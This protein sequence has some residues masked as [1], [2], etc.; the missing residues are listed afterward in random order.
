MRVG[1]IQQFCRL[2]DEGQSL[3]QPAMSQMYRSACA[4]HRTRS[5]KLARTIADL[6]GSEEIQ[7]LYLA[8]ARQYC[9]TLMTG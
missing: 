1:E 4:Y 6:A 2:Q 5:V 8:E 9:P 7:S 3:M